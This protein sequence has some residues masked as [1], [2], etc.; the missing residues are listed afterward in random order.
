MKILPLIFKLTKILLT[1]GNLPVA[2]EDSDFGYEFEFVVAVI[3][4]DI[5]NKEKT[6]VE[7]M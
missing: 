4:K 5:T 7:L 2:Y 6:F 3:R 1:E